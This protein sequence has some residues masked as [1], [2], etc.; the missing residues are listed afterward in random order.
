MSAVTITFL[1]IGCL[2]LLLL[3]LSLVGSGHL[4][5]GHLHLGHV[6]LGHFGHGHPGGGHD[7]VNL[8][9]PVI[10]GFIGAFGFGGAIAAELVP[11]HNALLAGG[12][13]LLAAFPTAWGAGRLMNAAINMPT[14]GTLSSGDLVGATGVV[15][16][17]VPADGFGE[18][19][20]T[21]GGQPMKFNARSAE[22]LAIGTYVFVIEVP[23]P[24]SVLVEPTPQVL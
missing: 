1:G 11:G 24:T 20:L 13:G 17:P 15:I 16:S 23:S 18:V 8:S 19:R 6:H 7:G 9:L 14:D 4:H 2:S 3:V 12:V 10:T 22:P 5:L 21:V